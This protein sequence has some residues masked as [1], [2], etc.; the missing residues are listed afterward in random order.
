[1]FGGLIGIYRKK[2]SIIQMLEPSCKEVPDWTLGNG[3][4]RT[5]KDYLPVIE[6]KLYLGQ[7]CSDTPLQQDEDTVFLTLSKRRQYTPFCADFGPVNLGTTHQMCKQLHHLLTCTPLDQKIVYYT[8][9]KP[10]DISNSMFLLGAFLCLNLGVTPEQAWQP[11][12]GLDAVLSLPF[13]DA[14]WAKS[15]F[16][17]HVQVC[18]YVIRLQLFVQAGNVWNCMHLCDFSLSGLFGRASASGDRGLL[19]DG[20]V[21]LRRILLLRQSPQWGHA[22]GRAKQVYSLARS[23]GR[24][25]ETSSRA[26]SPRADLEPR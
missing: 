17:L 1:L 13:R 3:A 19:Q 9:D 5:L 2:L 25:S 26:A 14:T 11:F 22:R 24:L 21:C 8:T 10:E 4:Q 23:G 15:S 20:Q 7:Y 16:D 6:G 18:S 12:S